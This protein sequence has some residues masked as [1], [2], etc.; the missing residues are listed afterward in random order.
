VIPTAL[1]A[2]R[3]LGAL[4]AALNI[5]CI[6]S[7]PGVHAPGPRPG[8]APRT[9]AALRRGIDSLVTQPEFRTAQWG[10]LIVDPASGDTL[11]SRNAGKF[12]LPASNMK[13]VTLAVAAQQLGLDYR[14]TTTV[15]A[16]G[17]VTDGVLAGDLVVYG[18]GD[19]SVSDSAGGDAMLP[20]RHIADSLYAAGVRRITGHLVAAG[21]AFPGPTVGFGW[22]WDDLDD[23][24]G[25]AIDELLF[26]DGFA[27][28]HVRGG[29]AAGDPPTVQTAPA[30]TYPRVRMAARTVPRGDSALTTDSL[31]AV[32]DTALDLFEVRGA[33]AA[34]DSATLPVTFADPDAAYL[35]AL[36]EALA[37]RGIVVDGAPA[38]TTASVDTLV[39]WQSPTLAE[40]MPAVFKPSQN[41]MAEMVFRTIGLTQ[42]GVGRADSAA[43]VVGDQLQAWGAEPDGY[44]LRDGSGMARYDYLTPETVVRVLDAVH[45]SHAFA[46]YYAALPVAGVD[47]TLKDRMRGTAAQN[48]VHAKTGSLSNARSLSGYVTTAGGRTLIFSILVNNFTT[49]SSRVAAVQDA[50]AEW[51]AELNLQ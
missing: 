19:P 28:L 48:N 24:D 18:R 26:N 6:G 16:R 10:V 14:W 37:D 50:I 47:G 4:F 5:A 23:P 38:D 42:T 25:A 35:A 22:S 1:R 39:R 44:L 13:L 33:I 17:H 31:R 49:K 46:V 3:P 40:V 2:V 8:P 34:G 21:N 32:K 9:R 29:A 41:Q 11:Y 51:L 12:F 7:W 20:L 30:R 45:R 15:A 27:L 43:R 36:H